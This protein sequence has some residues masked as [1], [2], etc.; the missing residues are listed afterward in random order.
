MKESIKGHRYHDEREA[1]QTLQVSPRKCAAPAEEMIVHTMVLTPSMQSYAE[2]ILPILTLPYSFTSPHS[3]Q[4]GYY[5]LQAQN[6]LSARS[7]ALSPVLLA[8]G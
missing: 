2:F 5:V 3:L 7:G 8:H 4:S 6:G 1:F